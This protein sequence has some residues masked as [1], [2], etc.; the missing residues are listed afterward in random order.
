MG[1]ASDKLGMLFGLYSFAFGCFLAPYSPRASF[2]CSAHM[3]KCNTKVSVYKA[4]S[5]I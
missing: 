3:I 4:E 2:L 1:R 5:D